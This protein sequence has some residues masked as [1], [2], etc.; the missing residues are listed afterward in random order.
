MIGIQYYMACPEAHNTVL[1]E[2]HHCY[3]NKVVAKIRVIDHQTYKQWR[4]DALFKCYAWNTSPI[5][6]TYIIRSFIAK[7]RDFWLPYILTDVEVTRIPQEGEAAI[8][9]IEMTFPLWFR[10]KELLRILNNK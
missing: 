2:R 3:L 7:S 6:G 4:M 10:Q 8:R 9:H 1:A 5:N